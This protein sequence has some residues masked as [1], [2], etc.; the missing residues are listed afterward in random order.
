MTMEIRV[1]LKHRQLAIIIGSSKLSQNRWAQKLGIERGHF[2]QLLQGQRLYPEVE[3][4]ARLLEGLN[5]SF[6]DIFEYEACDPA[7]RSTA[8]SRRTRKPIRRFQAQS[9]TAVPPPKGRESLFALLF[10]DARDALRRLRGNPG[11]CLVAVLTLSVGIGANSAIYSLLRNTLLA[12]LPFRDPDSLAIMWSHARDQN[13]L[14]GAV[15]IPETEDQRRGNPALQSIG[16]FN[17]ARSLSLSGPSGAER[18]NTVWAESGYF[19]AL[20]VQAALGRTLHQDEDRGLGA[21]PVVILSHS[22]W[23]ERFAS[24]Q[25]IVGRTIRLTGRSCQIIGVMPAHFR[26]PTEAW[27]QKPQ[28]WVPLSM[29]EPFFGSNMFQSRPTRQYAAL[30]RLAP[31]YTLQQAQAA[32]DR[33]ALQLES[34]FPQSQ[35]DRGIYLEP[36]QQHFYQQLEGPLQA[37]MAAALLVLLLCCLNVATLMLVRARVRQGELALRAA[38]GASS[39]RLV[40]EALVESLLLSL[41][42]A[43]AGLAVAWVAVG[44]LAANGTLQLPS[45]TSLSLDMEVVGLSILLSLATGLIFGSLPALH[46]ARVNPGRTLHSAGRS[47]RGG[48]GVLG[49]L[50]AAETALA[51]V[52]LVG[53]GLTAKSL[54]HFMRTKMG[55]D[56]HGL[57]SL[58]TELRGPGYSSGNAIQSF[59]DDLLREVRALPDVE[60]AAVWGPNM[61]G[62][63]SWHINLTPG[64][65]DA[66]DERNWVFAQRLLMTPGALE[67]L[68]I[69]LLRGRSFT[70]DDRDSAQDRNGDGQITPDEVQGLA[71]MVDQRL[72]E[73]LWPGEDALGKRVQLWASA[74][75]PATVVGVAQTALHRGRGYSGSDIGDVYLPFDEFP[76]GDIALL[77]RYR[78]NVRSTLNAVRSI[79][80]RL[81]PELPLFDA[82]TMLERL[83]RQEAQPRFVAGL[84]G[85]YAA[86]A[87]FLAA[88]GIFGVLAF[89]V[90][91]RRDEMALRSALGAQ[92]S[93]VMLLVVRQ[94]MMPALAGGALG[95]AAALGLSRFL[96][97]LLYEVSRNDALTYVMV[98]ALVT[99]VA[100]AACLLPARWASRVDPMRVLREE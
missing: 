24:D 6:D 26:D 46:A 95:M 48:G 10:K 25:Q 37:L 45:F 17:S 16:N 81:D 21:H 52:L 79:L 100:L 40:R 43:G 34:E 66:S 22:F 23:K 80:Q 39:S 55:F 4:R 3:T 63:A 31:G 38:L 42:G 41:G 75:W 15:S 58:R 91:R 94:G 56:S 5:L 67:T 29:G 89:S 74:A 19:R 69:P 59:A 71:V 9:A 54:Y 70:P 99:M 35:T 98:A 14:R 62:Q 51:V 36:L 65:R 64:G 7:Q 33:V 92:R 68:G 11:Y 2:S 28:I 87:T 97:S 60:S 57:L 32:A 20:G 12:P 30:A 44:A 82:V 88:V 61:V 77:V 47:V 1:R 73:M 84:M 72:A 86:S 18:L 13:W 53:A 83:S 90:R 27:G 85:A 50:V 96:E 8:S 76:S 93:Q 78:S 49:G